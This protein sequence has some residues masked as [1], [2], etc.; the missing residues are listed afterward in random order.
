[1]HIIINNGFYDTYVVTV[2]LYC[3]G[4]MIFGHAADNMY[5]VLSDNSK[6]VQH[7]CLYLS[8]ITDNHQDYFNSNTSIIFSEVKHLLLTNMIV[9]N[10]FNF[11]LISISYSEIICSRQK[12]IYFHNVVNVTIKSLRFSQ[13]GNSLHNKYRPYWGGVVFDKCTNVQI[14]DVHIS[15]PVGYGI[16]TI[17]MFGY[18]VMENVSIHMG[19]QKP[20][21]SFN[22]AL[23]TCSYGLHL[24][25]SSFDLDGTHM[26]TDSTTFVAISNIILTLSP[27]GIKRCANCCG[28]NYYLKFRGM[29]EVFL[30]QFDYTVLITIK[31]SSFS[32]LIG[33]ILMVFAES[34][35]N[36]SI[37]FN[38]CKITKINNFE[39][40]DII[41]APIA[42][43]G[44][45]SQHVLSFYHRMQCNYSIEIFHISFVD[46]NFS[47][48]E[49]NDKLANDAILHIEA[50]MDC[51]YKNRPV[52]LIS[53]R[54]VIFYEN[55][56]VLLHV[57]STALSAHI[58]PPI[59]IITKDKFTIEGNMTYMKK[60]LV[61]FKNA[62][63]YFN[64]ITVFFFNLLS[65]V[66][67]SDSS[68]LI[69]TN[70]TAFLR[71]IDCT[72]LLDLNGKWLY[73][74]LA[75]QANFTISFN[76]L[77]NE[78]ISVSKVYN[79]PF[80]YCIYFNSVPISIKTIPYRY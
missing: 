80:P 31:N 9:Q 72:N 75:K 10:V 46:C 17:N 4:Q 40:F 48:N 19:R 20:F 47:Y 11:S 33:N 21:E 57:T 15:N 16:I 49:Y 41:N 28:L 24:N 79:N 76:E 1:M 8:Y 2:M 68:K 37:S 18:N 5:N 70:S 71:N 26:Q 51:N 78:I 64:G 30:K 34:L 59:S 74:L 32:H 39:K 45:F 22:N 52:M 56:F 14:S 53:F 43:T 73:I 29:F 44:I 12:F 42:R 61:Y 7:P 13:C 25:Y 60:A 77:E 38:S 62:W 23:F 66:I 55:I 67:Y 65:T 3:L 27:S 6:C 35:A 69:F 58:G 36:N 54:N 63:V 50:E